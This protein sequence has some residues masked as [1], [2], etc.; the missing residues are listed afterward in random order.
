MLRMD[1]GREKTGKRMSRQREP[2][3]GCKY[4]VRSVSV[5][6]GWGRA[7]WEWLGWK[8]RREMAE[9]GCAVWRGE[10]THGQYSWN[11]CGVGLE[12]RTKLHRAED[13]QPGYRNV[14]GAHGSLLLQFLVFVS[15]FAPESM[16]L[17]RKV[18]LRFNGSYWALGDVLP[19]TAGE[20]G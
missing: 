11:W 12:H 4:H 7:G 17:E 8:G 16:Y 19:I 6:L 3:C 14:T 9:R 20:G 1:T 5:P 13:V 18:K 2:H 15:G 10:G